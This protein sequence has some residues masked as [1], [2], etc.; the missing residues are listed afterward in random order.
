[1]RRATVQLGRTLVQ[2]GTKLIPLKNA[3]CY[4]LETERHGKTAEKGILFF[5]AHF[6]W[7]FRSHLFL[8]GST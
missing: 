4:S 1:M 2:V 7:K 8:G 5:L 3:L 6:H